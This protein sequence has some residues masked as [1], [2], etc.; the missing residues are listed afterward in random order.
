MDYISFFESIKYI[1]PE[2][3]VSITL[4][5]IVV[6]DLIFSNKKIISAISVLG[7]FSAGY[8]LFELIGVTHSAF[9]VSSASNR[10]S[11][12]SLQR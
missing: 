3:A 12:K 2:I 6:L 10:R 9:P 4:V 8:F 5:A 7:L 11:V 1:K